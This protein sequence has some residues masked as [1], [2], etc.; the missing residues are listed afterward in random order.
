ME[1]TL[2]TI[3]EEIIGN[4]SPQNENIQGELRYIESSWI[5]NIKH[6]PKTYKLQFPHL[7]RR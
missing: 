5:S 7:M 6:K 2:E 3:G 1:T 4:Y